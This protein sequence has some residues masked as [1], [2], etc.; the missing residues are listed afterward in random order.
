MMGCAALWPCRCN[1]TQ[2][3]PTLLFRAQGRRGEIALAVFQ[4]INLVLS[5]IAYTIAAGQ[6]GR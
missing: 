1:A 5:G 4:Y 2:H 6:S 3:T